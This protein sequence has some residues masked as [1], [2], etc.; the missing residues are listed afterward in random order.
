MRRKHHI[1]VWVR[2]VI[3][4]ARKCSYC[5]LPVHLIGFRTWNGKKKP[6]YWITFVSVR[7]V[8]KNSHKWRHL[9]LFFLG[10]GRRIQL[11]ISKYS[12]VWSLRGVKLNPLKNP[13]QSPT[14]TLYKHINK[15]IS[16]LI[17]IFNAFIVMIV[18]KKS[19]LWLAKFAII[20]STPLSYDNMQ[21]PYYQYL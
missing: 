5:N 21:I 13:N 15:P 10:P 9:C 14:I 19:S 17:D 8:L 11:F 6:T 20:S 12:A 4:Y 16:Y 7:L 2:E 18:S 1:F 3:L